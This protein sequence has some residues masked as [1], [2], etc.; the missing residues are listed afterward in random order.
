[1]FS[2]REHQHGDGVLWPEVL[3][4]RREPTAAEEKNARLKIIS[5]RFKCNTSICSY[6]SGNGEETGWL[7][8]KLS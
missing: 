3:Q 7:S 6:L 1:M 5:F 8:I 4:Q 2:H